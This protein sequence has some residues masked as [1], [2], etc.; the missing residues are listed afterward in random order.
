MAVLTRVPEGYRMCE[1]GSLLCTGIQPCEGCWKKVNRKVVTGCIRA[2]GMADEEAQAHRFMTQWIA[3]WRALAEEMIA[4]HPEVFAA[5]VEAAAAAQRAAVEAEAA[6][7]QPPLPFG[8]MPSTAVPAPAAVH[9]DGGAVAPRPP[10]VTK[11]EKMAKGAVAAIVDSRSE[12]RPVPSAVSAP[13]AT[14]V[15]PTPPASEAAANGAAPRAP[16]G[17]G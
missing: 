11:R 10:K 4:L 13:A 7:Q 2:L 8:Q 9:P 1:T 16:V 6:S 14:S 5:A 15:A 17:E 12:E 3:S